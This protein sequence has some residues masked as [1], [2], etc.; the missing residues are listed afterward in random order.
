MGWGGKALQVWTL[1]LT[2]DTLFTSYETSLPVLLCV[3]ASSAM[4][5]LSVAGCEKEMT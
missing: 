4:I 5:G 1:V 3:P 2:S